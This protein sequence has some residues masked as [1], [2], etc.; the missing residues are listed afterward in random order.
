MKESVKVIRE[1]KEI[2]VC[3]EDTR[4]RILSLLMGKEMSIPEMAEELGKDH[5]TVY[6]HVKKLEEAGF[7]EVC[8]EIEH[9][10]KPTK[11]YRRNADIFILS[12]NSSETADFSLQNK[13][14]EKSIE[15]SLRLLNEAGMIDDGQDCP[16][17]TLL[18]FFSDFDE[19]VA[20]IIEESEED[21]VDIYTIHIMELML[22]LI[23]SERGTEL[24]DKASELASELV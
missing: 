13:V 23:E 17:S 5:S 19:R 11:I 18:D 22:F 16:H 3:I 4:N 14:K 1:P 10:H 21:D 2:K 9:H 20:K 7:L 15:K 12:P 8:A 6:R 24:Y